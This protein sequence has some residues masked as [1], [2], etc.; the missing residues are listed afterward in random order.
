MKPTFDYY[1]DMKEDKNSK[2]T[3][4]WFVVILSVFYFTIFFTNLYFQANFRY[5]QVNGLSMQPTL[6]VS[7]VYITEKTVKDGHETTEQKS[8]QDGVYVKLTQDVDYGD[9]IIVDKKNTSVKDDYT[10]IKRLLGKENDKVSIIKLNINGNYEYRFL[11]IKSG[12]NRVEVVNENYLE[13]TCK[14][15]SGN[16]FQL[17]YSFWSN[18]PG[19]PSEN[20]LGIK[21]EGSF[22]DTFFWD[23]SIESLNTENISTY[24]FSYAGQTYTNVLFYQ[25]EEG[26]IFYM[27]DN[28]AF[29]ADCRLTGT[30]YN[31]KI[32]GKVIEITHNSAC[33]QN[34]TFFWFEKVKGYIKV[35]WNKIVENFA[36]KG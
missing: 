25:I 34:S 5:I 13:G 22:F 23:N 24:T 12:S 33:Y 29:S 14:D 31:T 4:I 16:V 17:S 32:V 28:R 30:E 7:P 27:G 1:K 3:F 21:Y 15:A 11:R 6:N 36:W 10:V 35:L 2:R 26:K 9:I 20:F 19:C 18:Y 8:V